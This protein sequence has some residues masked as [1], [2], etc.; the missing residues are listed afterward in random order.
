MVSNALNQNKIMPGMNYNKL[1][2]NLKNLAGMYG[3]VEPINPQ[4][5]ASEDAG[6][7]E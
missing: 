6:P 5:D 3:K 7:L 4:V 1:E 2:M